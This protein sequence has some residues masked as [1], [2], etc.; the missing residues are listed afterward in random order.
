MSRCNDP[1]IKIN[2][3]KNNIKEVIHEYQE[4]IKSLYHESCDDALSV[5]NKCTECYMLGLMMIRPEIREYKDS[6]DVSIYMHKINNLMINDLKDT[7]A[8]ILQA[9]MNYHDLYGYAEIIFK[10]YH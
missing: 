10:R 2:G 5:L 6:I 7:N 8:S 4:N 1:I 9:L 3:S